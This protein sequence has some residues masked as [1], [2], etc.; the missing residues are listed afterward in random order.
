MRTLP[1]IAALAL[2]LLAVATPALAKE[3]LRLDFSV[4]YSTWIAGLADGKTCLAAIDILDTPNL[5]KYVFGY[6]RRV[7]VVTGTGTNRLVS[8]TVDVDGTFKTE[9][10]CKD[11]TCVAYSDDNPET[12]VMKFVMPGGK[13]AHLEVKRADGR[14]AGPFD[15]PLAGLE[16]ALKS[17]GPAAPLAPA[18]EALPEMPSEHRPLPQPKF[19]DKYLNPEPRVAPSR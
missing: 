3:P 7:V 4:K 8:A 19:D 6:D 16:Q 17:C 2:A 12:T 10:N 11:E 1:Y 5:G 18:P 9:L 15:I 13:F 14:D